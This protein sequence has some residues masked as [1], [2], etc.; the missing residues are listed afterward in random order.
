M[1]SVSAF[2]DTPNPRP[3]TA[4][5]PPLPHDQRA[6]PATREAP[7]AEREVAADRR[8]EPRS[9]AAH[10][11]LNYDP[12]HAAVYVEILNPATGDVLRRFPSDEARSAPQPAHGGQVD[13]LA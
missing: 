1:A 6:L 9:A 3:G 4:A 7:A 13:R 11:R 5:A 8:V 10:A 12:E 2:S